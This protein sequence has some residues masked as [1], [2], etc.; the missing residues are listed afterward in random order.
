MASAEQSGET[1]RD[2]SSP[3]TWGDVEQVRLSLEAKID[4][5][6]ADVKAQ[7]AEVEARVDVRAA[8]LQTQIAE[9][10]LRLTRMF[11][12]AVAAGVAALGILMG[13]LQAVD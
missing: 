6:I 8:E 3:S 10:E 4:T 2:F 12:G 1:L 9:V 13:I 7:V 11:L 5:S